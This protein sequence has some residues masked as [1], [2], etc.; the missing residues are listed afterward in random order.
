[1]EETFNPAALL[2]NLKGKD[3]LPVAAR[4]LWFRKDHP[5]EEGWGIECKMIDGGYE[6]GFAVYEAIV[7]DP[8]GRVI[9]SGQNVESKGGFGDFMQKAETGAIGRAL[10]VCG[11]GTMAA[12]DEGEVV[13]T[14]V[15]RERTQQPTVPA[16]REEV[17]TPAA[18]GLKCYDCSQPITAGQNTVSMRVYKRALCPRCQKTAAEQLSKIAMNPA[19]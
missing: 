8:T 10:G 16:Q 9:A 4:V 2:M 3:Y 19:V 15:A 1:M 12:L 18:D 14:P 6:K 17:P 7:T 11:Y 13:D 5:I